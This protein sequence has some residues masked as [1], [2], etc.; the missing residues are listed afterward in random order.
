[1]D[2]IEELE[3]LLKINNRLNPSTCNE[4]FIKIRCYCDFEGHGRASEMFEKHWILELPSEQAYWK[5]TKGYIKCLDGVIKHFHGKEFEEV[6][7]K[8]IEYM[9]EINK[10]NGD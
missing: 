4:D 6:L 9:K 3:S 2:K 8:A 5:S 7:D 10:L 1:M